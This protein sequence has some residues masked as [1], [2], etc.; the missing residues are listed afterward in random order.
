MHIL[1]GRFEIQ[2]T[3]EITADGMIW[4]SR[5]EE[6]KVKAG[7]EKEL[8]IGVV[9]DGFLMAFGKKWVNEKGLKIFDWN[10]IVTEAGMG[11][12]LPC[13]EQAKLAPRWRRRRLMAQ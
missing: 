5:G 7:S 11:R 4:L 2:G 9:P 13:V 3:F 10:S 12:P 8:A 1:G 6:K